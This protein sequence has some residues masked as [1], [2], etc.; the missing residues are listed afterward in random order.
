MRAATFV[1]FLVVSTSLPLSA[2]IVGVQGGGHFDEADTGGI[3]LTVNQN[4]SVTINIEQDFNGSFGFDFV[5]GFFGFAG[6]SFAPALPPLP[7]GAT[8]NS[9]SLSFS[10][11]AT[12]LPIIDP[13]FLNPSP[14]GP[15]QITSVS[16]GN[17]NSCTWSAPFASSYPVDLVLGAPQYDLIVS[18]DDGGGL[19]YNVPL[20]PG[21]YIAGA[22]IMVDAS[23]EIDVDYSVAPEPRTI[24]LIALGMI[25][26]IAIKARQRLQALG[27]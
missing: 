3:E 25:V 11:G 27:S 9:E 21:E 19:L 7:N 20:D 18:G 15:I 6:Q 16:L 2:D 12:L 14:Q 23:W 24:G 10:V 22:N 17:C 1:A 5:S 8:I 4:G 13:S 26:F